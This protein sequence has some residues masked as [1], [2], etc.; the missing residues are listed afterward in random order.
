MNLTSSEAL[1]HWAQAFVISGTIFF[2]LAAF[3]VFV[4]LIDLFLQKDRP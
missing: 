4:R 2:A 1:V 3:F